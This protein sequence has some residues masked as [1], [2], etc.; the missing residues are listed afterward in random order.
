MNFLKSIFYT[1]FVAFVAFNAVFSTI[2]FFQKDESV[3]WFSAAIC[4]VAA[5]SYFVNLYIKRPSSVKVWLVVLFPLIGATFLITMGRFNLEIESQA[6][7][8]YAS[9]FVLIGWTL[10]HFWYSRLPKV[11]FDPRNNWT[12]NDESGNEVDLT[13]NKAKFRVVVFHRGGSCPFSIA[14]LKS[15]SSEIQ[16]FEERNTQLSFVA[17]LSSKEIRGLSASTGAKNVLSD[18]GMKL[19][20]QLGIAQKNSIPA[21]FGLFGFK[22]NQPLPSFV[23]TDTNGEVIHFESY[24]DYRDRKSVGYILRW[25]D[26]KAKG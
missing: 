10:Y 3:Y 18:Q 9:A 22:A 2:N 4:A 21:G 1:V 7:P 15:L 14:H 16:E 8:V 5:A 17:N 13:A 23:I 11:N 26:E 24:T 6:Y 12:F 19:T 25:L 20:S